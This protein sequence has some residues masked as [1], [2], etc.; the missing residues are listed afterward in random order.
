MN[1]HNRSIEKLSNRRRKGMDKSSG[2]RRLKFLKKRDLFASA[3]NMN[4]RKSFWWCFFVRKWNMVPESNGR[5]NRCLGGGGWLWDLSIRVL[6]K[7]KI[8]LIHM[9]ELY[10]LNL[11]AII[12][13][14]YNKYTNSTCIGLQ[15]ITFPGFSVLYR[16]DPGIRLNLYPLG[17]N[18]LWVALLNEA[19]ENQG[20]WDSVLQEDPENWG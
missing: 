3:I 4:V 5:A 2:S 13:V 8:S 16:C 20:V 6:C 14:P 11:S 15:I 18:Q 12:I 7:V 9:F 1:T 17:P 10:K 19:K